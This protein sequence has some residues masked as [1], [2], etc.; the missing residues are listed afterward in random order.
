MVPGDHIRNWNR[1]PAQCDFIKAGPGPCAVPGHNQYSADCWPSGDHTW[2][3]YRPQ[4]SPLA[5]LTISLLSGTWLPPVPARET[6][7]HDPRLPLHWLVWGDWDP[8]L[9]P[10]KTHMSYHVCYG[11]RCDVCLSQQEVLGLEIRSNCAFKW[12][13]ARSPTSIIFPCMRLSDSPIS[14]YAPLRYVGSQYVL[15]SLG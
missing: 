14:L 15:F 1:L 2:V 13:F 9:N 4:C 11:K 6:R 5:K 3:S 7:D 10:K 12:T 8:I